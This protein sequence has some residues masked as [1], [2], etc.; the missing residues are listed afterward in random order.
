[1][2]SHMV[3]KTFGLS[4]VIVLEF[5]L[6]LDAG[7]TEAKHQNSTFCKDRIDLEL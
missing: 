1:M 3:F 4:E 2:H 5:E 7:S 6:S